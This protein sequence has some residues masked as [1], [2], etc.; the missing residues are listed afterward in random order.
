MTKLKESFQ[1]LDVAV[2]QAV[3]SVTLSSRTPQPENVQ[4]SIKEITQMLEDR[5]IASIQE[6]LA[7]VRRQLEAVPGAKDNQAIQKALASLDIVV[8]DATAAAQAEG[9]VN[10]AQ[11]TEQGES[12]KVIQ[13][14]AGGAIAGAAGLA[15][16]DDS[17]RDA[18]RQFGQ[19]VD[20]QVQNVTGAAFFAALD[21]GVSRNDNKS[22]D[23]GQAAVIS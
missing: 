5:Q 12:G 21:N 14:V 13:E 22:R 17:T 15:F 7:S 1:Q 18:F 8:N 19:M 10:I 3:D 2:D 11:Q 20:S 4:E 6:K 23:K 9:T 16:L